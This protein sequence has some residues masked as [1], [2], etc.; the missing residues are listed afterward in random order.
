MGKLHK[1]HFS[2]TESETEYS[3][4]KRALGGIMG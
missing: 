3:N 4:W 2:N 1:L